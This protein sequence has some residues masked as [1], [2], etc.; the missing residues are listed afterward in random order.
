ML[1]LFQLFFII[2][3]IPLLHNLA[4]YLILILEVYT[5][6]SSS[7]ALLQ[8]DGVCTTHHHLFFATRVL[9]HSTFLAYTT[10]FS[11]F[12]QSTVVLGKKEIF[13]SAMLLWI[14]GQEPTSPALSKNETTAPRNK[15]RSISLTFFFTMQTPRTHNMQTFACS[16][17]QSDNV[18]TRTLSAF[19]KIRHCHCLT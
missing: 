17:T 7:P 1:V 15:Y 14:T 10:L 16:T 19:A 2:K 5:A 13:R 3:I 4:C 11:S 9:N 6:T 18:Y 12:F 8:R